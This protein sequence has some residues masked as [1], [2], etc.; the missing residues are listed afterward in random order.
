MIALPSA[1][2]SSNSIEEKASENLLVSP[3]TV[4][5]ALKQPK[6]TQ[7]FWREGNRL[8]NKKIDNIETTTSFKSKVIFKSSE[9]TA[10]DGDEI[11]NIY[12]EW[13][14]NCEKGDLLLIDA[15]GGH[16]THSKVGTKSTERWF[17]ALM[18]ERFFCCE[19]PLKKQLKTIT[20]FHHERY[21]WNPDKN[22][23]GIIYAFRYR[24]YKLDC[25]QKTATSLVDEHLPYF[26]GFHFESTTQML[27]LIDK[28]YTK[29]RPRDDGHC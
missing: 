15:E 5:L 13:K 11:A 24:G 10:A 19:D 2:I 4:H 23:S 12:N 20:A 17:A 16:W 9:A 8:S 3:K 25:Y 26:N 14:R 6:D 18:N 28:E 22:R 21:A 27:T 1:H 29:N 7:S